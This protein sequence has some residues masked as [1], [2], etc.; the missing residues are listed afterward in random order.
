[1]SASLERLADLAVGFAANVQPGQLLGI[2]ADVGQED[3]V[4]AVAASAYRRGAHFVDVRYFDPL[5]KRARIEFAPGPTLDYVPP[6]YGERVLAIGRARG[7][8]VALVGTTT[9]GALDGL[10]PSRA[11]RDQLPFVKET[12]AVIE[13]REVNWTVVP[14][15]TASWAKLVYPDLDEESALERMWLEIGHACRLDE[16]DPIAAWG[17]RVGQLAQVAER[18]TELRLDQ[19]CFEGPGTDL[20]VGLLE[21]SSWQTAATE[22]VE[23]IPHLANLPTEEVF[24]TPDPERTEGRVRSTRPLVLFDGTVIRG[25]EVR[26][27]GGRAV[28]IDADEG[29]KLLRGRVALDEGASKLGEVALVDRESRIG[30]LGTVFYETLL[31]EN[32]VSHVA[33][34]H[35]DEASVAEQDRSRV[36]RSATHLD[37]MIGGDDVAV[38]GFTRG[39]GEVPLLR[40]GTWQL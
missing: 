21:S 6:W 14:S 13:G 10:D 17:E 28:A 12:L 34:G 37:F 26:F 22:T 23:G 33:L 5:V 19:V 29:A 27:E 16:V 35:G 24:A 8:N 36:N 32:A 2:T 7:A 25:L 38:T 39:G 1:M 31:D 11:A 18:L 3:V 30:Q 15:P 40:G 4:R 9:P 20:T